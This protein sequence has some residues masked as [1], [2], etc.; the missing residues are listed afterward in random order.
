MNSIENSLHFIP[1][2][3]GENYLHI[4]GIRR[5][6]VEEV[7]WMGRQRRGRWGVGVRVRRE[8]Q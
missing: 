2:F 4:E 6:K 1:G 3:H 7:E 5:L 8:G